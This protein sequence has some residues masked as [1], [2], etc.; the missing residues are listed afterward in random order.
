MVPPPKIRNA[1]SA[2]NTVAAKAKPDSP[3]RVAESPS[4]RVRDRHTV[5]Y[6]DQDQRH[7]DKGRSHER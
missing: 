4:A 2:D 1:T 6:I 5:G 3:K 7:G